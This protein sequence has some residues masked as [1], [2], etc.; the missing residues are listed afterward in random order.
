MNSDD[1]LYPANGVSTPPIPRLT[2][3]GPEGANVG[4]EM[5]RLQFFLHE[6]FGIWCSVRWICHTTH[7]MELCSCSWANC[8]LFSL[9]GTRGK[10]VVFETTFGWLIVWSFG[11]RLSTPS[12]DYIIPSTRP[13]LSSTE[14]FYD[15]PGSSD[16]KFI[17]V[18][19]ARPAPFRFVSSP[20]RCIFDPFQ[21][22]IFP[23]TPS[24]SIS[25]PSPC[26]L[27]NYL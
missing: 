25:A 21:V 22:Y 7:R 27:K 15:H 10:Y 24:D 23:L 2:S 26:T 20:P 11:L 18:N 1:T 5:D 13:D 4:I 14:Q 16:G 3:M 6:M 17:L 9:I 19:Q 12:P 8:Y